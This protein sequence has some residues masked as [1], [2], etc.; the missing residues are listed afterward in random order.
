MAM[1]NG[2]PNITFFEH[3]LAKD[4]VLEEVDGMKHCLGADIL[5]QRNLAMTRF[6][7]PVTLLATGGAGQVNPLVES[8][9]CKLLPSTTAIA[10]A[11][12]NH[13]APTLAKLEHGDFRLAQSMQGRI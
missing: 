8:F 4:L 1:A 2:N 12:L 7:S 6:V 9:C 3:H 13:A 11:L 5:D 10:Q